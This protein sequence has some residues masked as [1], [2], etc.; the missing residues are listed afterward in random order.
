[1][2]NSLDLDEMSYSVSHPDPSC[3]HM[4]LVVICWLR[5]NLSSNIDITKS[6]ST[7]IQTFQHFGKVWLGFIEWCLI[8]FVC[9]GNHGS[10]VDEFLGDAVVRPEACVVE[11]CVAVLVYSVDVGLVV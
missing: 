10:V 6:K 11:G 3:L 2:S 1:M 8:K 9:H 4:E 7:Y 5:V